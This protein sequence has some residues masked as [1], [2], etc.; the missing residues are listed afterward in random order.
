LNKE[1]TADAKGGMSQTTMASK[2]SGSHL[3]SRENIGLRKT[4]VFSFYTKK[5]QGQ[6]FENVELDI[7]L[8][9]DDHKFEGRTL[10]LQQLKNRDLCQRHSSEVFLFDKKMNYCNL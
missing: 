7:N 5:Q 6:L 4:K 1:W 9:I 3:I 8:T 2:V 10:T